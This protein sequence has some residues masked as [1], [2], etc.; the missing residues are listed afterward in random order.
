MLYLLINLCEMW[1]IEKE[2]EEEKTHIHSA[3]DFPF[4]KQFTTN[5]AKCQPLSCF[6]LFYSSRAAARQEK[7]VR[8]YIYTHTEKQKQKE[9]Y[10]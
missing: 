6:L 10:G 2:N 1:C 3:R 5:G 9:T 7:N 8:L 4:R